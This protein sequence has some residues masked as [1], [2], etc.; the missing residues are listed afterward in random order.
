MSDSE[1]RSGGDNRE[2]NGVVNLE[3]YVNTHSTT[4]ATAG[5]MERL[6]RPLRERW[7]RCRPLTFWLVDGEKI[8]ATR[9]DIGL[10]PGQAFVFA[11]KSNGGD[12][13][14]VRIPVTKQDIFSIREFKDEFD[15]E[16]RGR[17]IG[18]TTAVSWRW[19]EHLLGRAG[20]CGAASYNKENVLFGEC[21]KELE[22]PPVEEKVVEEVAE[23]SASVVEE[24]Q[25]VE[26]EP[27]TPP[28]QVA[29]A[30][31]PAVAAEEKPKEK[32]V[33]PEEVEKRRQEFES[34]IVKR[35]EKWKA[36]KLVRE[37]GEPDV[38]WEN[39][40]KLVKRAIDLLKE[41]V[42]QLQDSKASFSDDNIRYT[43]KRDD[44]WLDDFEKTYAHKLYERLQRDAEWIDEEG[45]VQ[46]VNIKDAKGNLV[47]RY[48]I[49]PW[50]GDKPSDKFYCKVVVEPI[51][52]ALLFNHVQGI[53]SV[54]DLTM[55]ARECFNID[56]KDGV[57]THISEE[58]KPAVIKLIAQPPYRGFQDFT[59]DGI[60]LGRLPF[61]KESD[62]E[63]KYV[64]FVEK[65][66]IKTK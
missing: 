63:G 59:L 25:P 54:A 12:I 61:C 16:A 41:S 15:E 7:N 58:S 52:G 53:S 51:A 34:K 20:F 56:Y 13:K 17:K 42:S 9:R 46:A 18:S 14:E 50:P 64:T 10:R 22:N 31:E 38:V 27:I 44:S 66:E 32:E 19:I 1:L 29:P 23:V 57:G 37:E 30:R 3:S 21:K 39:K 55:S 47:L 35:L 2:G 65:G 6:S 60:W 45:H 26:E 40:E 28:T 62:R 11:F 48:V 49:S 43:I 24:P 5:D 33:F 4:I 8:S 36:I